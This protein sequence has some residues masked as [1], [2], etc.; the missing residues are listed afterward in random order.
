MPPD[1]VPGLPD[2]EY[3]VLSSRLIPGMDGGYTIATLAR[4]RQLAGA[5]VADGAGPQLLTFDPGSVADHAAH[6]RTF[7]EQG[8]W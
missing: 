5:G 6:R 4:A 7:A 3:L 8:R 1:A 2:A